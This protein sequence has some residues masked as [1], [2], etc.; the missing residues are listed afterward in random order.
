M[1]DYQDSQH[2]SSR[3]A[4]EVAQDY[5]A[6]GWKPI[7]IPSR[8]KGPI[9]KNWQHTPITAENIA[10]H[11]N[12]SAMNIG[13]QLGAAS[14]NLADIDL[15]CTEAIAMAPRLLPPT[16]AKFGRSS[17][18]V[19]HY[20]Y[21]VTDPEPKASIKLSDDQKK[22]IIELRLEGGSKGAQTVFPGSIHQSGE[23][24][25]WAPDGDPAK[26]ACAELIAAIVKIAGGTL[27]A[28]H[29]PE[30]NRHDAA[31]RVGG[32]LARCNWEAQD[33]GYFIEVVQEA[34][35]VTDPN[36]IENG[37]RAAIN[38]AEA[39]ARGDNVYGLPGLR[40]QFTD[41]V[42][43]QIAK[44]I[45]YKER[46]RAPAAEQ[47][48]VIDNLNKEYALVIV[49]NSASVMHFQQDQSFDFLQVG[50]FELWLANQK[51]LINGKLVP[52]GRYWLQHPQR[53]QYERIVFSPG[54]KEQDDKSFNLWRGFSVEPR[55]GDCSKF[56]AT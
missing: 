38:A 22:T 29:W 36:H 23:P 13:V 53:R 28:R 44:L 52:I 55:P 54:R 16:G 31:L 20:L 18:P 2:N 43:N 41:A 4:L 6:R 35:G 49:S 50:S 42:A 25:Q 21:K 34:A 24:I 1:P 5:L 40:E 8:A 46:A 48:A 7:P 27:I 19:S 33:I 32:F 14:H 39:H 10:Q 9:N 37:R 3:P 11:F 26:A 51:I 12:G 15:D 47:D 45:G 56:L 30:N 17:K